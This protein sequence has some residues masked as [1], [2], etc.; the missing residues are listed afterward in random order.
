MFRR[1][2]RDGEAMGLAVRADV[3]VVQLRLSAVDR[4]LWVLRSVLGVAF[5]VAVLWVVGGALFFFATLP[6]VSAGHGSPLRTAAASHAVP[7][8]PPRRPT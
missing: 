6:G 8:P 4:L 7:Q 3:C 5:G 1:P 2:V